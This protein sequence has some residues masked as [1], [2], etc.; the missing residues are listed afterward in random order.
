MTP[1]K[2]P[3]DVSE[4]VVAVK[5]KDRD[6]NTHTAEIEIA[7]YET[8]EMFMRRVEAAIERVLTEVP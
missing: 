7:D 8:L 5:I 2:K 6:Y 1:P 3:A 4:I